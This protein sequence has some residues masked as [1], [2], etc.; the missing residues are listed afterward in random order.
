MSGLFGLDSYLYVCVY[1]IFARK[2]KAK[3]QITGRKKTEKNKR[4]LSRSQ[5]LG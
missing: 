1:L 2:K 3:H 4:L 5:E